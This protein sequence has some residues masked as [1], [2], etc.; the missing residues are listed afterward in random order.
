MADGV[1]FV[2]E[3]VASDRYACAGVFVESYRHAFLWE[4]PDEVSPQRYLDSIVG[5][6][7]WVALEG[8]KII[9]VISMDWSENF[10]HS[11]YVLPDHHRRGAGSALIDKVLAVAHGP[12]EL[13]CDRQNLAAIEFYRRTGWR[14]VGEGISNTGPWLRFRKYRVW[15]NP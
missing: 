3:A 8:D 14:E 6:Q 7:Q 4:V 2:R 9:A 1:I 13:K 12:C 5:E 11:L 10:V 15:P